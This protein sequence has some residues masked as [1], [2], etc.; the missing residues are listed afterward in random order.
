MVGQDLFGLQKGVNMRKILIALAAAFIL[1]TVA[2]VTSSTA[3]ARYGYGG[4]ARPGLGYGGWGRAGWG[5]RGWA[6]PGWGYGGWRYGG[7]AP[8]ALAA[9][10]FIGAAVIPVTPY[11]PYQYAPYD[12]YYGTLPAYQYVPY[13]AP[14]YGFGCGC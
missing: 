11:G 4:W 12:Y 7:W 3:D 8:G 14:V 1:G 9:G 10:A 5:H 13:Y 2:L 6:R